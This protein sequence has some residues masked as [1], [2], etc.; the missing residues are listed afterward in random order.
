MQRHLSTLAAV[1]CLAWASPLCAQE[2][3]PDHWEIKVTPYIW[4]TALSGHATVKG[5]KADVDVSF[6]D[7][8]DQLEGGALGQL[9]ATKG[10]WS[11]IVQG[12]YLR[13]EDTDHQGPLDV[14]ADGTTFIGEFVGAYRLGRWPLG[15][16]SQGTAPGVAVDVLGGARYT[17]LDGQLKLKATVGPLSAERH[18][19]QDKEWVDP[20][21]GTRLI[22]DLTDRLFLAM[23]GDVGGFSV[24]SN[25]TWN[26]IGV[27]GYSFNKHVSAVVG[28]RALYQDYQDGSFEYDVTTQGPLAGVTIQW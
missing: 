14:K 12:N 4:A 16:A 25:F 8:V 24:G 18:F 17:Y 23:R 1:G 6:S 15:K 10:P 11:L 22:V 5:H 20:I 28:Y 3:P 21:V 2:A 9:E 19:D 13:L 26:A 27:V 7:I